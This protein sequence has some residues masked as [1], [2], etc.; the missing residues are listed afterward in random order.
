MPL[1]ISGISVIMRCC[2]GSVTV[3]GV[4][5]CADVHQQRHGDRQNEI[6]V[7]ARQIVKPPNHG[8]CRN[9]MVAFSMR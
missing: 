8:A 7:A 5:F 4:I 6:R 9:S 3:I 1:N 2:E